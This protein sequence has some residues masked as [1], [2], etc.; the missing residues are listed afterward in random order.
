M[1]RIEERE[2]DKLLE[3]ISFIKNA[4]SRNSPLL[5]EVFMPARF[6]ILFLAV[7]L[8]IV[9]FSLA[10]Y[11][12]TGL[13]GGYGK[14]PVLYKVIVYLALLSDFIFLV[15]LRWT[16]I[17]GFRAEENRDIRGSLDTFFSSRLIHVFI[18]LVAIT[19]L[20]SIYSATRG[21]AY[22]I[23]PTLSVGMGLLYNFFGSMTG[24]RQWLISGYWFMG[25]GILTLLWT[26]PTP[27]AVLV[28]MGCGL[29]VFALLSYFAAAATT[30]E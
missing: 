13:Y 25:T 1:G 11:F 30:E 26:M 9:I 15:V 12:L 24:I 18:P 23:V 17:L 10:F 14:I 28:S 20:I 22:Y 29:L 7:G 4:I 16:R 6:R 5:Q 27:I 8:S 21:N 19:L 3:D 2:I